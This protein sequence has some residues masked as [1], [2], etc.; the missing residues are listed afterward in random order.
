MRQVIQDAVVLLTEGPEEVELQVATLPIL[1]VVRCFT[2]RDVL[3]TVVCTHATWGSVHVAIEFPI[4]YLSMD[5]MMCVSRS[6]R[7]CDQG[8]SR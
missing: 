2:T 7:V 1:Y 6:L 5:F 3:A 8:L 4:H